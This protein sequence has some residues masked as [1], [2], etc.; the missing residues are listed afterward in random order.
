MSKFGIDAAKKIAADSPD[1]AR[2]LAAD[3]R[4]ALTVITVHR[5]I[6]NEDILEAAQQLAQLSSHLVNGDLKTGDMIRVRQGSLAGLVFTV[7]TAYENGVLFC[8]APGGCCTLDAVN[9]DK[10]V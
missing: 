2:W 9:V 1:A 3:I 8:V 4:N 5:D 6:L 7:E 10:V